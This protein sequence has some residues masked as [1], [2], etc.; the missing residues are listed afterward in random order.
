[1]I[2]HVLSLGE[3]QSC[4]KP[5]AME[6]QGKKRRQSPRT[7]FVKSHRPLVL[8]ED[9]QANG[10]QPSLLANIFHLLHELTRALKQ[11]LLTVVIKARPIPS[12]WKRAS[13]CIS[14]TYTT[15][16]SPSPHVGLQAATGSRASCT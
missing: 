3:S 16:C 12:P 8:S 1:M 11:A 9:C 15:C 4:S 6:C 13:I 10:I 14:Y 7:S 5:T 2:F